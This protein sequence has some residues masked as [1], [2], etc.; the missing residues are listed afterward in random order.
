MSNDKPNSTR[1]CANG[2][3]G[4]QDVRS[5]SVSQT[6]LANA[7]LTTPS[8]NSWRGSANAQRL[9][10][11]T[12]TPSP[13]SVY[14][15]LST[16]TIGFLSSVV[17]PAILL[18]SRC[19]IAQVTSDGT[20]NTLVNQ[21]GN[22]F[23]ILNG[24]E[25]GNNLFHSFTNFSV[26]T[27]GSA[28]FDLTNTP[29]ITTIFSRVT[30]GNVSNIDGL[31]Q[32]LNGNN[33]V[34]LFLMN[35]AGIVF[36]QN[37]SLNIGG[38]F[39]GTT[40]NSIK[41]ADGIEFSAT[42]PSATPLLTMSVPIGLQ[43]GQNPGDITVQNTGHRLISIGNAIVSPLDRSNNPVGLGV[44]SGNNLALIGGE[45]A[46]DG[47][48][49]NA[50]SGHIELGSASNGTVNLNTSS[51][52]WNF[53]YGNI[54]QFG[55]IHLSH[56][57]L[58]DAS[59]TRAGSIHFQGRNIS[60]QD[61]SAALLVNQGSNNSGDISVNASES[62]QLGGVGTDRFTQTGLRADNLGDGAG[63]NILVSASQVF[64]YDGGT[65]DGFN[66]GK[67]SGSNISMEIGDLLQI[68][69]L[70]PIS[71]LSSSLITNT[72]NSGKSG[73]IQVVTKKLQ[74]LDG[75][76]ID[77]ASV[78]NGMA[79]KITINAAD[80]IEVM[81]QNL[82]DSLIVVT[83]FSQANA[84]QLTINTAKL[85]IQDGGGII[86]S[87]LNSGNG[88]DLL[89]NASDTV[90]VSGVSNISRLPS[91]IGARAELPAPPIRRLLGLPDVITGNTGKL[92]VNTP[93]L[94]IT[95]GAIVG[96]DHQ[97]IGNAGKLEINAGSIRLDNGGKI[98]AAT[99]QGEG[100]NIFIQANDLIM[101]HGSSIVTN[102][103]GIGNGGNITINSPIIVGWENS[104]II[105]NAF[106]G[107]GGNIQ[108]NTQG[109]FGLKYRNEL[110]LENDITASSKFGVNGTVDINN[111]GVDPSS[112][113][114]ELPVNL[115]DSSQQIATGCSNTNGSSFVATGRGGI[116]QNPLQQVT[117]ERTWS[118][119]RDLSAY[120]KIGE[121]TVQI[122]L[123]PETLVQ[124]T[125]W[126]RNA[127][128]KIELIAAQ[129]AHVQPS[130]NCAAVS[131]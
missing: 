54:K 5:R 13:R 84:G 58:A 72:T 50:P 73:D 61:G 48:V 43:M 35:P 83:T 47:G 88:G 119:I 123:T 112:G 57:S 118:D 59:G 104:D 77:N 31:I 116:P 51:P 10:E 89:I 97:S 99:V 27:N 130:L 65:V 111:F 102:A 109:I 14:A 26:P 101:A 34:S 98:T 126:H 121:V 69:G 21:S 24:I 96:V 1:G 33:Q 75:A 86:A 45:V 106:Q 8:A 115:T 3:G 128:G 62:L 29:N 94:Q 70:S 2:F 22:N 19:A 100:G 41:F 71:G 113:L 18:W 49:L 32:T 120:R 81:G 46:L 79:G 16:L 44:T 87:T 39:V 55:N 127:D 82:R 108:I 37:A 117:S 95:D 122:P 60:L 105:A 125:G 30:G 76:E 52:H 25:K 53:D 103:G 64:L 36:G 7:V 85:R 74:I 90:E 91:R 92:V 114:V 23:I 78:S 17:L 67:G 6:R 80:F 56:Q 93:R 38:S 63:G 66:F 12:A 20:T 28:T 40:A 107:N 9:A 11:K 131:N 42:N 129:I 15:F 124:A 68:V 110:T 4:S